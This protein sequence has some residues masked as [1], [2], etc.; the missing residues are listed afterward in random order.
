L[1]TNLV[2]FAAD[3]AL[4]G[5]NSQKVR[6]ASESDGAGIASRRRFDV[7]H[8]T[9]K[10]TIFAVSAA[11]LAISS[12]V[13]V[14][15]FADDGDEYGMNPMPPSVGDPG[16]TP[17]DVCDAKLPNDNSGFTAT[18]INVTVVAAGE[19][20]P[21]RTST[22]P[23]QILPVGNPVFSSFANHRNLH[24]NG[25]SPNI[26]AFADANVTTYPGGSDRY[27]HTTV[28]KHFAYQFG[29]KVFK[30]VGPDK[31]PKEVVPPG[32][33]SSGNL[34]APD[35]ALDQTAPGPDQFD[36]DPTPFVSMVGATNIEVVVCISPG[37]NK[38]QWRAQNNY[39]N[40]PACSRALYD[41]VAKILNPPTNSLPTT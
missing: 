29:C 13:S 7:G 22:T 10:K 26:H 9:M 39:G 35:P 20:P 17:Q 19:D 41:S 23:F 38:G 1:V 12:L 31:N 33:Q 6:E 15:V 18:P 8:W 34:T 5:V 32:L 21:V 4:D 11:A 28:T 27:F 37:N 16:D 30:I 14:P 25:Q 3:R 24:V 36:H 40:S 2:A